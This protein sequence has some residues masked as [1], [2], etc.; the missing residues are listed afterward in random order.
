MEKL[1]CIL[2]DH[3]SLD[4]V[5]QKTESLFPGLFSAKLFRQQLCYF[6]DIDYSEEVTY[7][8]GYEVDE[9]TVKSFLTHIATMPF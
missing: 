2:R 5:V 9:A 8:T 3:Y 7:M 6:N 1:C 4:T